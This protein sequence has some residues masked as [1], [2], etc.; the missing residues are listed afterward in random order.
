MTSFDLDVDGDGVIR[1][2]GELDLAGADR[3]TALAGAVLD[4]QRKVV[5]DV[6]ELE[7]IDSTGIRAVVALAQRNGPGIVLRNPRRNV[8]R[9]LDITG[10][11]NCAGIRIE[12]TS[13][14]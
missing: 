8:R 3:F 9:V 4:G 14:H 13:D 7:F 2:R 11:D 10:I 5:L 12:P 6:S 1:I